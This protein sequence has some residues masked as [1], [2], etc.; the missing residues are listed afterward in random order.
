M[1]R[2]TWEGRACC[3]RQAAEVVEDGRGVIGVMECYAGQEVLDMQCNLEI[4][5]ACGLHINGLRGHRDDRTRF[6][7][8]KRLQRL[9]HKGRVDAVF[10][11]D[12]HAVKAVLGHKV[13]NAV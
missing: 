1:S 12:I 11:V 2:S 5:I 4:R 8:S 9:S 10:K 3:L 13:D 7:R 6:A